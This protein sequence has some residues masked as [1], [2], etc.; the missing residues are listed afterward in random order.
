[1]SLE[2]KI[3]VFTAT[4][5]EVENIIELV[6][7]IKHQPSKPHLLIID[8]NSPDGTSEETIKEAM[9]NS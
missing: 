7:L 1:M 3:L 2:K 8:D 9:F 6:N 4:F 5:N